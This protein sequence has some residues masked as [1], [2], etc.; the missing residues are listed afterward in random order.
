[1]RNNHIKG[2]LS[3]PFKHHV[4]EQRTSG[5]HCRFGTKTRKDN[6]NIKKTKQSKQPNKTNNNEIKTNN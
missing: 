6:N 4:P 1:M 5:F 2:D 3:T